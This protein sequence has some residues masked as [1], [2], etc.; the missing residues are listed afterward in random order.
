MCFDEGSIPSADSVPSM[1][2][3][4]QL[5]D[6]SIL[7]SVLASISIEAVLFNEYF[8]YLSDNKGFQSRVNKRVFN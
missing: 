5:S 8:P 3:I 7:G 2:M 4:D 1:V 6:K